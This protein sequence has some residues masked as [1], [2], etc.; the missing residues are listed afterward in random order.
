MALHCGLVPANRRESVQKYLLEHHYDFVSPF[1]YLYTFEAFYQMNTNEADQEVINTIRK[2]WALM[3]GRKMPGTLG[4]DF[5]DESYY[6]HDF[7]PIPS[8]FLSSYV[9][10]VRRDVPIENRRIIVEPRLGDLTEAEGVVITRYGQVPVV[11]KRT[12]GEGLYFKI[13]IPKGVKA[14][15]SIP[16][17]SNKPV[18]KIDGKIIQ[19]A[20][21]SNRFLT[22]ELGSGAHAG[23][24]NP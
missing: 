15:V 10:G 20:K 3:V 22:V 8:A 1:A 2:R 17:C 16:K 21:L 12:T 7:G 18:L 19:K 5:T 4:E 13:N 6:C 11:W 14:T 9:L 23:T 24:I